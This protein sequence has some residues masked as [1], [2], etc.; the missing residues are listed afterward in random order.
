MLQDANKD[1][2]RENLSVRNSNT[3]RSDIDKQ[4]ELRMSMYGHQNKPQVPVS[5]ADDNAQP[6]KRNPIQEAVPDLKPITQYVLVVRENV[7]QCKKI[8]DYI[9][10]HASH[11]GRILVKQV[12]QVREKMP[13]LRGIPTLIDCDNERIYE[14]SAVMQVLEM[15]FSERSV[16]KLG[17]GNARFGGATQY[18]QQDRVSNSSSSLEGLYG[19]SFKTDMSKYN[20]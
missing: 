18:N 20:N 9:K 19:V 10:Q 6:P 12:E 15:N 17:T 16:P 14:G 8:L 7:E 13:Y 5:A 1:V 11:D 3:S 2:T 4:V